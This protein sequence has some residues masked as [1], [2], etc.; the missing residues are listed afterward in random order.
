MADH[1]DLRVRRAAFNA[2][3]RLGWKPGDPSEAAESTV[4]SARWDRA[5][6]LGARAVPALVRAIHDPQFSADE[7]K[8]AAQCLVEIG[9]KPEHDSD[10]IALA[11]AE[12]RF[13]QLPALDEKGVGVLVHLL[14]DPRT[15]DTPLDVL[16][17]LGADV[18]ADP[19]AKYVGPLVCDH[20]LLE[21]LAEFDHPSVVVP[22]LQRS[23]KRTTVAPP[24]QLGLPSPRPLSG[25]LLRLNARIHDRFACVDNKLVFAAWPRKPLFIQIPGHKC[26][27]VSLRVLFDA[28]TL[29]SRS[30]RTTFFVEELDHCH[31]VVQCLLDHLFGDSRKARRV[32]SKALEKN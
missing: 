10:A 19:L 17:Q 6:E 13:D 26:Q 24:H 21:L 9:W 22:L 27:D 30:F 28:K 12:D 14:H 31:I 29:K 5:G 4:V 8:S 15:R 3:E 1:D 23:F 2:L 25:Y 11:V 18:A 7:R 16:R 20:E 32:S